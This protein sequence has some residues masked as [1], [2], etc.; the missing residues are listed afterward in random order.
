MS[1]IP[2]HPERG[3][4][5]HICACRK[6]GKE[7]GAMTVG[8]MKVLVNNTGRIKTYFS[9]DQAGR[10][11]DIQEPGDHIREVGEHE[12]VYIGLCDECESEEKEHHSIVKEGGVFWKCKE[13][14][15]DGVIKKSGFADHIRSHMGIEAPKPCGVEFEKCSEHNG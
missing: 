1:N 15:R 2:I 3:L 8:H 12:S 9:T 13:C 7:T 5:P 11:L 6:C 10:A 4:D 14:H